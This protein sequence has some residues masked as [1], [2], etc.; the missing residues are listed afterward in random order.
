M[1]INV[2]G[3]FREPESFDAL[4]ETV[5][6]QIMR[7]RDPEQPVRVWVPAGST[8]E[9]AYSIAIALLEYLDTGVS[10]RIQ[11]FATDV[12]DTAI[13]RARAGRYLGDIS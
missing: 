8:G 12:S 2:T 4:R 1:L 11:F 10:P 7:E 13:E 3:F 6:P 5:F 9:E